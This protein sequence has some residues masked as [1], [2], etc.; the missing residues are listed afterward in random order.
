MKTRNIGFRNSLFVIVLILFTSSCRN[1]EISL[2]PGDD[3]KTI[4]GYFQK[5]EIA[6]LFCL[7]D[8]LFEG[9][10]QS[11]VIKRKNDYRRIEK[12]MVFPSAT[13]TKL[14]SAY[15]KGWDVFQAV[16]HFGVSSK[17]S[18]NQT[19]FYYYLEDGSRLLIPFLTGSTHLYD[20]L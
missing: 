14:P 4:W 12:I 16:E 20:A 19:T 3:Y 2:K 15:V 6:P 17:T 18:L 11:F 9:N 13:P 5:K 1:N 8:L 10:H 7:N